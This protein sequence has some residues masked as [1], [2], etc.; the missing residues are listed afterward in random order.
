M[1][2]PYL[3]LFQSI[4]TEDLDDIVQ[5]ADLQE[6]QEI[7]VVL[8]TFAKADEFANLAEQ[9]GQR[10][11]FQASLAK[12]VESNG[13]EELRKEA[14]LAYLAAGRLDKEVNIWIE[15]MTGEE[16]H[17][18]AEKDG[19]SS[20][21]YSVPAHALQTFMEKVTIFRGATKYEDV[22]LKV[23]QSAE[24]GSVRSYKLSGLYER[25]SCS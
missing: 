1:N 22:D 17:L 4:V 10:L 21:R 5:N 6:W 20:L 24:E 25:H 12:N 9:L 3:R 19:R 16:N 2:L 13:F 8:C 15:E 14:T 7:F 23:N 18:L 11:E